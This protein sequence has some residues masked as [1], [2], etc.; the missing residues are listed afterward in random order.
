[1]IFC[2]VEKS[3]QIFLPFCPNSRVWQTDEQPDGRH[4]MQRGNNNQQLLLLQMLLLLLAVYSDST[5]VVLVIQ[6]RF[7]RLWLG[8]VWELWKNNW[9]SWQIRGEALQAPKE[10]EFGEGLCCGQGWKKPRFLKKFF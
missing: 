7:A 1:M 9:G 10:V 3:G 5:V 2:V 4:S 8:A 6:S